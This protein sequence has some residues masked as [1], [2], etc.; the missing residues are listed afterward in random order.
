MSGNYRIQYTAHITR[1]TSYDC[2]E[3]SIENS[4]PRK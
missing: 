4:P 2:Y 3:D 1:A